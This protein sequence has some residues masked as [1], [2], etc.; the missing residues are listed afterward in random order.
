MRFSP[1]V[2]DKSTLCFLYKFDR[3]LDGCLLFPVHV[4]ESFV[5]DSFDVLNIVLVHMKAW[6]CHATVINDH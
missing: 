4:H 1:R 2:Y 5:S 3:F 6:G